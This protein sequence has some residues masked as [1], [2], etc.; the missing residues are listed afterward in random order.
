MAALTAWTLTP[1]ASERHYAAGQECYRRGEFATAKEHFIQ[2]TLADESA[3]KA[4]FALGRAYQ[5]LGPTNQPSYSLAIEQYEHAQKLAPDGKNLAAIGYCF[6]LAGRKHAALAAYR[7]AEEA[8]FVNAELLNNMGVCVID[9]TDNRAAARQFFDR[10]IATDRNLAAAYHNRA[11][12]LTDAAKND[13]AM[14][15]FRAQDPKWMASDE[16]KKMQDDLAAALRL[17][18]TDVEKML[19]LGPPNGELSFHAACFFAVASHVEPSW[20][21]DALHHLANAVQRQGF[22]A[23]RLKTNA[24][25]APLRGEPQFQTLSAFPAPGVMP[26][27]PRF[28][29]PI[30][31]SMP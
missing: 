26:R 12:L 20:K 8:G 11:I 6:H 16:Q 24:L 3:A 23:S 31:D 15:V 5:N 28:V 21:K 17:G 19:E 27:P 9:T 13:I 22:N 18:Q 30:K 25:L 14:L 29:D 4:F 7:E 1:P 10:A 2:A